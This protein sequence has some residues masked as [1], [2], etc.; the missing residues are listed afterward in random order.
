VRAHL[1]TYE[2]R[3]PKSL[4]EAL[5][6]L[7]AKP[8]EWQPFAGGTDLMVLFEAGRLAQRKFLSLQ[9]LKEL[10]GI[11]I[12]KKHLSI[13][14]LA[15]YTELQKNETARAELPNL[16]A[17]SS[18]T[19]AIA[20]QNRGTFGGNLANASPAADSSPA[21][22]SYGAELELVSPNGTRR[23]SYDRFH[24]GYKQTE[25]KPGELIARILVPRTQPR[26]DRHYFRKVGTRRAQAI[27][28]VC[29]A[30]WARVEKKKIIDVRIGLGSVGPVPLRATRAEEALRGAGLGDQAA[31]KRAREAL[32]AEIRPIDD[33]RSLEAYRREVALNLLEEF[34]NVKLGR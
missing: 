7:S 34:F 5:K 16:I 6:I 19:G 23:A 31:L 17:A 26:L 29:M 18:E 8:G 9:G 22:L 20:I 27:S 10:S 28:K 14:A 1:P 11:R 12:D 4:S 24:L 30:G 13:G 2:L 33:I 15:T 21:F 3:A 32:A 25:L